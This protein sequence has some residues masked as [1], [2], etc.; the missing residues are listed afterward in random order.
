MRMQISVLY[1]RIMFFLIASVRLL[2][3]LRILGNKHF[4]LF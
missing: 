1:I 4:V 2:F 3:A